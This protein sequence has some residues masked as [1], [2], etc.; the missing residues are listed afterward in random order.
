VSDDLAR[1]RINPKVKITITPGALVTIKGEVDVPLALYYTEFGPA[2]P[3]GG[4]KRDTSSPFG[5]RLL[6]SESG[7]F[8]I[9]GIRDLDRVM[10]D[11][12]VKTTGECRIENSTIG[13]IVTGQLRLTGLASS[14]GASGTVKVERGQVRLTSGLFLKINRAEAT[15]PP[16]P[17][18]QQPYVIFEGSVGRFDREIVISMHGPMSNPTLRLSSTP[19]KSD[20]EILSILAFGRTPGSMGGS[21]VLGT[22]TEKMIA[23][24]GDAWPTPDY[25]ESLF[26]RLGF[27]IYEQ[28]AERPVPPWE[29]PTR[30]TSRGTTVRSEYLLNEFLSVVAE[31]DREANLS[32][33][34]KLR[35]RFR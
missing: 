35:L 5:L 19:P 15:L 24:Y 10:L 2:A 28:G 1:I 34:L 23:I 4:R 3:E 17:K 16:N 30:G 11:V 27:R 14:P 13:A 21:D 33:D 32:G 20:E 22:V 29:L 6:P 18:L 12:E 31:S 9:P 8:R 7:G 26:D 25:E